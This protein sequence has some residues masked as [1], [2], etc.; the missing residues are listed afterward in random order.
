MKV[1]LSRKTIIGISLVAVIGCGSTDNPV[2]EDGPS[3]QTLI[4]V[5]SPVRNVNQILGT[6]LLKSIN[7]L[8]ENGKEPHNVINWV[9]FWLKFEPDSTFQAT[10]R[11]PI[12]FIAESELLALKGLQHI[13]KITVTFEGKYKIVANQLKM[14]VISSKVRPKQAA[15]LD[16][17]FENPGFLWVGEIG[18]AGVAEAFLDENG[19]KL[20]LEVDDGTVEGRVIYQRF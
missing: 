12:E 4:T 15:E 7:V 1:I 5:F 18:N 8:G 3:T 14:N 13:E 16:S 19:D 17:D 11:Y 20:M 6:W 2:K 9:S 10:H